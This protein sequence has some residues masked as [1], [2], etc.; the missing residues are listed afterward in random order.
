MLVSIGPASVAF[1]R[2]PIFACASG[3][4]ACA[5]QKPRLVELGVLGDRPDHHPIDSTEIG[6]KHQ[7]IA[8]TRLPVRWEKVLPQARLKVRAFPRKHTKAL[9]DDS[10]AG[11]VALPM[12]LD[13][14]LSVWMY[15]CWL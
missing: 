5:L 4:E 6:T 9:D 2:A 15:V 12:M 13:C 7:E 10:G 14:W 11:V 3:D 1:R 8:N